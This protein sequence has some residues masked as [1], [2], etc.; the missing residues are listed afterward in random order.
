[1]VKKILIV[2]L[3]LVFGA[4]MLGASMLLAHDFTGRDLVGIGEPVTLEGTLRSEDNEWY[5]D[6]TDE[7]YLLHVGP[8]DYLESKKIPIEEGEAVSVEGFQK[9]S[10][11]AVVSMAVDGKTYALRDADGMPLWAGRGR[12]LAQ[13]DGYGCRH[14]FSRNDRGRGFEGRRL[15]SG[16]SDTQKGW[17]SR[18]EQRYDSNNR[19]CW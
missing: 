3:V 9:D 6:T 8:R 16:L 15:G 1:M 12:R 2:S 14:E 5:L 4:S 18:Q 17:D 7:S 19:G 13:K 11:V 10:D